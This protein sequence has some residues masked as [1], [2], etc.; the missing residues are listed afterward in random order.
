[1]TNAP[2]MSQFDKKGEKHGSLFILKSIILDNYFSKKIKC[3]S[4]INV[5]TKLHPDIIHNIKMFWTIVG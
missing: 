1:M 5:Y 4:L 3:I 2:D